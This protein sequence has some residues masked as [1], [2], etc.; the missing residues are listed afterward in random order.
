MDFTPLNI[1][2]LV[3]AI[4]IF[5]VSVFLCVVLYQLAQVLK[6]VQIVVDKANILVDQVNTYIAKPLKLA[7]E[8][9]KRIKQIMSA[10]QSRFGQDEEK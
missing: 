7:M 5:I 3:L 6:E 1:L 2:Y 4:S 8:I 9:S 10:V